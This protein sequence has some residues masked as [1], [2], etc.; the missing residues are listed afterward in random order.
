MM[1]GFQITNSKGVNL[2]KG[3]EYVP[4]FLAKRDFSSGPSVQTW[5]TGIPG[6]DPPPLV[7]ARGICIA[8]VSSETGRWVVSVWGHKPQGIVTVYL[9]T[10]AFKSVSKYGVQ[11]FDSGGTLSYQSS[12]KAIRVIDVVSSMQNNNLPKRYT[13]PVAVTAKVLFAR[14]YGIGTSYLYGL[15]ADLN[16]SVSIQVVQTIPANVSFGLSYASFV[17]IDVT[18]L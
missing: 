1:Y 15:I 10:R 12:S 6:G 2:I 7:F 17:V 18:G 13:V 5:D 14:S 8:G 11:V 16:N 3:D 9:F 4:C